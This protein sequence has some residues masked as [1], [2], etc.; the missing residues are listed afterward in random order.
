MVV[1]KAV[2]GFQHRDQ[3][4]LLGG[5][6]MPQVLGD[7][8]LVQVGK[9]VGIPPAGGQ[10]VLKLLHKLVICKTALGFLAADKTFHQCHGDLGGIDRQRAGDAPGFHLVGGRAPEKVGGL[11]KAVVHKFHLGG[12]HGAFH[13][14]VGGVDAPGVGADVLHRNL[15]AVAVEGREQLGELVRQGLGPLALQQVGELPLVRVGQALPAL[16]GVD[17]AHKAFQVVLLPVGGQLGAQGL[18]LL[19]LVLHPQDGFPGVGAGPQGV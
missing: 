15:V 4:L 11:Q 8:P 2:V 5:Q 18:R 10:G 19:P 9:K 14:A 16:P 12:V 13:Q 6:V 7:R 3:L 17:A 1:D